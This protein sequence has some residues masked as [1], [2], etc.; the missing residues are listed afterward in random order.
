[1]PSATASFTPIL[2]T[3]VGMLAHKLTL[4]TK[5]LNKFSDYFKINKINFHDKNSLNKLVEE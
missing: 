1:M 5:S 2:K 3:M 4:D